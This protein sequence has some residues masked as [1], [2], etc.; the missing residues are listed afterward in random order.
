MSRICVKEGG[1]GLLIA[2]LVLESL[3]LAGIFLRPHYLKWQ[4][5]REAREINLGKRKKKKK[6]KDKGKPKKQPHVM[7]E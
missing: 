2:I 1:F 3:A 5:K 4:A 7:R 6:K